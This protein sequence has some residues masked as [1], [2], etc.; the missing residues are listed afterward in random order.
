MTVPMTSIPRSLLAKYDRPGPRYTSYPP[1]TQ[2]HGAVTAADCAR[3]LG[4][5]PAGEPLSIYVHVPFCDYRCTYCGC[6]VIPTRKHEVSRQYL[7]ACLCELGMVRDLLPSPARLA[8]VHLGGGTPTYLAPGEIEELLGGIRTRFEVI[9]GAEVS[10]ELDPR[11]TTEE[12]LD[13]LL[14]IGTNR[15]SMG[16]QDTSPEVQEAI[17]RHQTREQSVE[18]FRLCRRKGFASINV[19]LVYGLPLQTADRF[20]RTLRDILDLHPERFAVFGYAHVPW[21]KANQRGISAGDL[22]GAEDRLELY[23]MA[24]RELTAAGYRHIGMDHFALPDDDLSRAQEEGRL[25]R[26]FMGYIPERDRKVIGIG[27]SSIGDLGAGYFQNEKKLSTYY[28][29]LAR[30]ELPVE[31][32]FLCGRDD[33]VRRFVVHEILCNL[34]LDFAEFRERFGER[35]EEYFAGELEDV[36][37]LA[38]DGLIDVDGGGIRVTPLGKFL[39]RN[40]AMPFDLYLRERPPAQATYSRTV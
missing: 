9:P 28:G 19:D 32:G 31:R 6:H 27:V 38:G 13:A 37:D 12:H 14:E 11:V 30:G 1:A 20:A 24:H 25:G 34:K 23:L 36:R 8:A 18:F 21:V 16:V 5:V 10:V 26:S 3:E 22:P 17:G 33:V 7:D 35:F 15:I 39:L 40:I 2:F 4:N 29:R